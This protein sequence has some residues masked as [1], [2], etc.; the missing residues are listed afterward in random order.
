M[1]ITTPPPDKE[2]GTARKAPIKQPETK[3]A[4]LR[5]LLNRKSGA[6]VPA[7]QKAT[8][9]QAHSVRAAMS[10]LRKTGFTIARTDPA[11]PRGAPVY[12]ITAKPG[13][14]G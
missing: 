5:R 13:C 11:N 1:T 3:A 8:G 10:G 2:S 9:W 7:L 14:A 6:T 4:I 12:R